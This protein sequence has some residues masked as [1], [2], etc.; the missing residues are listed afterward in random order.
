[1]SVV[2]AGRTVAGLCGE[3]RRLDLWVAQ[4]FD[5]L[6]EREVGDPAVLRVAHE[7]VERRLEADEHRGGLARD[8]RHEPGALFAVGGHRTVDP[9]APPVRREVDRQHLE[10][11]R[12]V[13]VE[14]DLAHPVELGRGVGH[15]ARDR[16]HAVT[17]A[18]QRRA[19][20]DELVGG[21]GGAGGQLAVLRAVQ[22]RAGRRH[23]H[24]AGLGGLFREPCHLLDLV[25][26][27]LVVRPRRTEHVGPQRAVGQ[28]RGD[29]EH[30]WHGLELV[31]VLGEGLP[32]PRHALVERGT[33]DVLDTLHQLDEEVV[34]VGTSRREADAAVAHD[35]GR[36]AVPARR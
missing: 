27:G 9:V 2:Q 23:A 31:E 34:L 19:D 29:V 10:G 5:A 20:R 30:P 14:R 17:G 25:G 22:D 16:E 4:A 15:V 32:V 36:D 13:G 1:M 35:D 11:H 7:R 24:G 28:Q 26:R 12:D 3:D 18:G 6:V 33:G 8:L 21:G